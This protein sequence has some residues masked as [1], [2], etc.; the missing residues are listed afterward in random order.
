M[1]QRQDRAPVDD[2][3]GDLQAQCIH[4]GG[5]QVYRLDQ[6]VADRAALRF[7]TG[8]DHDEGHPHPLFVHELLLTLPVVAL[9]VAMVGGEYDHGVRKAPRLVEKTHDAAEVVI[10]LLHQTHVGRLHV[11]TD[12]VL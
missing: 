7:R 1:Q 2:V 11:Q 5:H 6:R 4:E 10:D 9:V 8:V 12:F 3:G